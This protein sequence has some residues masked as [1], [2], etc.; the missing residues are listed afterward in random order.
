MRAVVDYMGDRHISSIAVDPPVPGVATL[1]GLRAASGL[2]A[3]IERAAPGEVAASTLLALLLDDVPVTV[4]V[5]GHVL[6]AAGALHPRAGRRSANPD[7]CAGW[8]RGGTIM[9]GVAELGRTPVAVGPTAPCLD[10]PDDPL[11]WHT[12]EPMPVHTMRRRRRLDLVDGDPVRVDALFRD[13]A[14]A[15]DGVERVIHEYAVTA[16]LEREI[17]RLHDVHADARVL[18]W[19]ECPQAAASS[20][21]LDGR[22]VHDLRTWVRQQLVGTSTCTH[23][24]DVLRSLADLTALAAVLAGERA[25]AAGG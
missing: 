20:H 21:R 22:T 25:G 3:E 10:R 6:S 17:L 1:V 8:Q 12:S 16:T 7:L 4:L 15:E 19:V 18:P 13:S 23:L 14:V 24:N 9:I 11:A 5:S 2:R